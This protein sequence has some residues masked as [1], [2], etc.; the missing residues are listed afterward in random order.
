MVII[1][2]RKNKKDFTR[3]EVLTFLNYYEDCCDH[4]IDHKYSIQMA[5]DLIFLKYNHENFQESDELNTVTTSR[6]CLIIKKISIIIFIFVNLIRVCLHFNTNSDL[7]KFG[8]FTQWIYDKQF[9]FLIP[10]FAVNTNA[11]C[12]CLMFLIFNSK[13]FCWLELFASLQGFITPSKVNIWNSKSLRSIYFQAKS[14]HFFNKTITYLIWFCLIAATTALYYNNNELDDFLYYVL[15]WLLNHFIWFYFLL[16]IP[17]NNLSYLETV[18]Y[19]LVIRLEEVNKLLLEQLSYK[20]KKSFWRNKINDLIFKE[21]NTICL[22]ISNYNKF[23]K[24]FIF[25]N[26][27]SF[28]VLFNLTLYHIIFTSMNLGSFV[29]LLLILLYSLY[30]LFI[31]TVA[32]ALISNTAH[33]PYHKLNSIGIHS[34]PVSI[35]MN[36]QKIIERLSGPI[37]GFTCLNLFTVTR[38]MALIVSLDVFNYVPVYHYSLLIIILF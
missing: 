21:H 10:I 38:K 2:K 32:V 28:F 26:Y 6:R 9:M 37:I 29:I 19:Y 24:K 8:D 17:L 27:L 7:L 34:F 11:I 23:W 13:N 1:K 16:S 14:I 30:T 36:L 35:G 33:Q 3:E 18:S 22:Q 25:S 12:Q 31:M 5:Q 15:P 20:R 4:L